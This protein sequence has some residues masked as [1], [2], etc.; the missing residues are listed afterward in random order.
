MPYHKRSTSPAKPKAATRRSAPP[1]E[2]SAPHTRTR[3]GVAASASWTLWTRRC[4]PASSGKPGREKRHP[5]KAPGGDPLSSST[6]IFDEYTIYAE[7]LAKLSP[8]RL[9]F[10]TGTSRPAR[11]SSSREA[12]GHF[13]TWTMART[14]MSHLLPPVPAGPVPCYRCQPA[15]IHEIIGISKAYVTRVGSGPFPTELLDATGEQLRQTGGEFGATNRTSAALR[16]V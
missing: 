3:S 2:A 11:R 16:L 15:D 12:Q 8:I 10:F 13:L 14:P 9:S 4:S 5:G 6:Q 7:T 1:A